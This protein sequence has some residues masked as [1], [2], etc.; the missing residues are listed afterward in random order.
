MDVFRKGKFKL[1]ALAETKWEGKEEL[2]WCG[3]SGI[4]AILQ[5]MERAR[6]WVAILLIIVCH[7]VL[8]D[9]GDVSSRILCIKLRFSRVKVCVVVGYGRKEGNVEER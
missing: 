6:E 9:F 8:I 2:S 4:I 1:L 7:S 3:V 5:E